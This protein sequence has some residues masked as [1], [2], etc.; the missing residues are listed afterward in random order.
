MS[1]KPTAG[2]RFRNFDRTTR[3]LQQRLREL[4]LQQ[5]EIS[6][7]P[8]DGTTQVGYWTMPLAWDVKRAR[9]EIVDPLPSP[10]FRVLADYGN[11]P[12]SLGMWE[13]GSTPPGGV[14]AE[15][16]DLPHSDAA[17]SRSSN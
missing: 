6:G 15:L 2:S 1:G 13:S 16:V 4:G 10:E 5:V 17:T 7:A 9:L 8:A 3:Y 11:V 14:I 12:A